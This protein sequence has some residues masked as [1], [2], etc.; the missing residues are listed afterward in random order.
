[1]AQLYDQRFVREL[2][3]WHFFVTPRMDGLALSLTQRWHTCRFRTTCLCPNEWRHNTSKTLH[4]SKEN[5]SCGPIIRCSN[6]H[7]IL[8]YHC[9]KRSQSAARH[10][11]IVIW[12]C[13]IITQLLH[14][15][16][17]I[18]RWF[19][20]RYIPVPQL[21]ENFVWK[22]QKLHNRGHAS[23]GIFENGTQYSNDVLQTFTRQ[24][25]LQVSAEEFLMRLKFICHMNA[26]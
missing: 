12:H 3:G 10:Y 24:F 20:S 18:I 16:L 21:P 7:A 1:M 6:N 2:L 9:L 23:S 26:W 14:D 8:Y 4:N 22:L 25:P 19:Y 13:M 5:L 17:M 11:V 15:D